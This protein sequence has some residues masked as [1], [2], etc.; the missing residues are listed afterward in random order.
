METCNSHPSRHRIIRYHAGD[1]DEDQRVEIERHLSE[2]SMCTEYFNELEKNKETFHAAHSRDEFIRLIK[3]ICHEHQHKK[4]IPKWN[5]KRYSLVFGMSAAMVVFMVLIGLGTRNR[6]DE[7]HERLKGLELALGYY[8][9]GAA[10]PEIGLHDRVLKPDDRIQ[11]H[12]SAPAGGYVH[13]FGVDEKGF[14]SI[15]FPLP[16]Q[17]P[18]S[19]PGGANRPVPGSVILD[20]TLGRERVFLLICEKPMER[21]QLVQRI[22]GLSNNLK[23]LLDE[24]ELPLACRQTS[25][26]LAKSAGGRR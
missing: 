12:V 10:G 13:I 19:F 15:Y 3:T 23:S 5:F 20:E 24:T 7:F 1:L 18:E 16:H 22:N 8:I 11:F 9:M 21:D 2:C 6:R 4:K 17:K 26:L 14:L 25:I